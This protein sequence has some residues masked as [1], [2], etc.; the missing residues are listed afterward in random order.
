MTTVPSDPARTTTTRRPLEFAYEDGDGYLFL[1]PVTLDLVA[2]PR[3]RAAG[4]MAYVRAGAQVYMAF[5]G[6]EPIALELPAAV[7]LLV[8][9]CDEVEGLARLETGLEV[10][11]PEDVR[12][13]D[14]VRIDTRTGVCLG[15]ASA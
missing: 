11:I 7:D 9:E 6:A 8:L 15:R 10:R 2:L 4:R 5:A 14:V 12:S 1:D 3:E 13:G